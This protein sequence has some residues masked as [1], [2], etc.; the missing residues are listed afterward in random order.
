MLFWGFQKTAPLK[1]VEVRK[2]APLKN[3]EK[4]SHDVPASMGSSLGV[5]G[6]YAL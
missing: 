1:Q 2:V 4:Y 5:S 6:V 3:I